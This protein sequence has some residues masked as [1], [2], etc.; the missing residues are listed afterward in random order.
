[1]KTKL[2]ITGLC[3]LS[4]T[5]FSCGK[6][7]TAQPS[8]TGTVTIEGTTYSTIN[9]GNQVWTTSNFTGNQPQGIFET[10]ADLTST[11]HYY[12]S[13]NVTLPQ[14]WRVPTRQDFNN[15]I[16]NFNHQTSGQDKTMN[17]NDALGLFSTSGWINVEG[18]NT[19]GFNAYPA[20]MLNLNIDGM[21][22]ASFKGDDAIFLSSTQT[23]DT[24]GNTEF[25]TLTLDN[26]NGAFIGTFLA[27]PST[28]TYSFISLRFVRDK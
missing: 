5:I 17:L 27:Q 26:N 9:I 2:I 6:K 18:T 10:T 11:G 7:E 1:M 28:N 8:S 25:Y 4:F 15:L 20:G 14:G 23:T 16:A 24:N 19:S 3:L 12:N 13:T 21:G 22:S